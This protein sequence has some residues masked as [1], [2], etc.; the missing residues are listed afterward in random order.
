MVI[1][2]IS[3]L[4]GVSKLH[5]TSCGG[6]FLF[7]VCLFV[8][9]FIWLRRVLVSAHGIFVVACGVFQ[10][11]HSGIFQLWHAGSL[12]AARELLAAA[13]GIQFPDQ[14]SNPGPLHW[15]CRVLATG[16]PGKSPTS[17]FCSPKNVVLAHS[18]HTHMFLYCLWQLSHYKDRGEQLH[19]RPYGRHRLNYLVC[20]PFQ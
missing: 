19:E 4:Q 7:F 13:C 11:R 17:C 9:L 1:M 20:S 12:V 15:E 10:L 18:I 5:P 6:F 2:K 3:L 14:G 16:P 8:Y